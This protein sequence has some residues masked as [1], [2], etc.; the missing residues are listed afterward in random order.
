MERNGD[1]QNGEII[2]DVESLTIYF[3]KPK[4]ELSPA[5]ETFPV[6]TGP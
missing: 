6:W 3:G 4:F 1:P 5:D 2:I